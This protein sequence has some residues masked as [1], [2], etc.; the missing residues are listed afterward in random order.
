[1]VF[2]NEVLTPLHELTRAINAKN[3][4]GELPQKS[5]MS[6]WLARAKEASKAINR[7]VFVLMTAQT[8]GWPFAKKLDFY[9]SG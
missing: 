3:E 9:Q 4:S 1:M 7:R 5:D 8:R 6:E 2:L